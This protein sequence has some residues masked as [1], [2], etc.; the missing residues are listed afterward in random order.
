MANLVQVR[1]KQRATLLVGQW[2]VKIVVRSLF[3][4]C[5]QLKSLD[6]DLTRR[7]SAAEPRYAFALN[8]AGLNPTRSV[9][10]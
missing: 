1:A 8:C 2:E 4:R 9:S 5:S 7:H 10:G 3:T 6:R